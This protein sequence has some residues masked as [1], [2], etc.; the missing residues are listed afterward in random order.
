MEHDFVQP[1]GFFHPPRHKRLLP[2]HKFNF[3]VVS[4]PEL[5]EGI[6]EVVLCVSGPVI[7]LQ[8]TSTVVPTRLV[9]QL[10]ELTSVMLKL[11][12][13]TAFYRPLQLRAR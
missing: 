4:A 8:S 7:H 10:E 3:C 13:P 12:G 2:L 5:E 6:L 11:F 9:T 1:Q